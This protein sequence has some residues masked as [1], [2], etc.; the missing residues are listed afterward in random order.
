MN[1]YDWVQ[2]ISLLAFLI[3]AASSL[4]SYKLDWR[5]GIKQALIWGCL[6]TGLAL[7]ISWL[8]LA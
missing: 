6:F 4:A 2:L 5:T 8:R 1:E 3:L 7:A